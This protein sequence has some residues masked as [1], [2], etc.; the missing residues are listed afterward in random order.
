MGKDNQ[1]V[2]VMAI[3]RTG[4]GKSHLLNM[5]AREYYFE[6]NDSLS[7]GTLGIKSRNGKIES[8][9]RGI[10]VRFSDSQGFGE[11]RHGL[12]GDIQILKD[13]R[14]YI[15]GLEGGLSLGLIVIPVTDTRVQKKDI[16]AIKTLAALLGDDLIPSLR[17]VL[18]QIN[19]L[20]PELRVRAIKNYQRE[21]LNI[22]NEGLRFR[23]FDYSQ[24][25]VYYHH[26][27]P[28]EL[29]IEDVIDIVQESKAFVPDLHDINVLKRKA[30]ADRARI[31]AE[32]EKT[33][34]QKEAQVAL[35]N[36]LAADN[37]ESQ[38]L[39]YEAQQAYNRSK[40]SNEFKKFVRLFGL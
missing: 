39:A 31:E 22:I 27:M 11:N 3:G 29:F 13:I 34:I 32:E 33:R 4:A 30:E 28:V 23:K 12:G 17:I 9:D 24:V 19:V 10:N 37:A 40:P 2:N 21:A 18:T 7:S 25:L 14:D 8:G 38:R 1:R 36:K 16:E 20:S 35:E 6:E 5:L 15:N 26:L